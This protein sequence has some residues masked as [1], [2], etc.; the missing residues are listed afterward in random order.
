M[1]ATWWSCTPDVIRF[2]HTADWQL[3][4]SRHFLSP[5]AQSRFAQDRIEAIRRIGELAR[6]HEAQFAV[7][8]GDVFESNQVERQT[9][10]RALD[11]MGAVPV[12]L[13]LLPGNHD[14]LEAASVYRCP[15]FLQKKPDNVIVFQNRDP[16]ELPGGLTGLEIIGVPW[17]TKRPLSDLTGEVCSNLEPAGPG[18]VRVVVGHGMVDALAPDPENPALVRV[19]AV[20]AALQENRLHYLA[21]GDRHS[22]T[23]VGTSGAIRYSGPPVA[24]D[25]GEEGG[26]QALLVEVSA[27]APTRVTELP[28]GMWR[29]L[30]GHFDLNGPEDI[31]AL[32]HWLEACQNKERTIVRLGLVGSLRVADKARVDDLQLDYEDHF[33]SLRIWERHTDLAVLPDALDA[34]GLDLSGYARATWEELAATTQQGGEQGR[35]AAEA[36]ALLFRLSGGAT[37]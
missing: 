10:A 26:G 17:E 37:P 2:I 12:P 22:A 9:I 6:E 5:E 23:S 30:E 1:R 25:F 8:C 28:V 15:T 36:L 35:T 24:T 31:G 32:S 14:P 19:A 4:M 20:E 11:A 16:V 29:F 27:E 3:G 18:V 34:E 13:L 21:L 7:V 33:A